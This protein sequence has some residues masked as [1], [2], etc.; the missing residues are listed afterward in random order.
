MSYNPSRLQYV[1]F[2]VQ[3]AWGT[4]ETSGFAPVECGPV[5][6][7]FG[8][9]M[10]SREAVTG[11]FYMLPPVPG[12]QAVGNEIQ[13]TIP[14]MRG[15]S[16][17]IPTGNP[18]AHFEAQVLR[19]L[20]GGQSVSGFASSAVAASSSTTV[21]KIKGA[22]SVTNYKAGN[23]LIVT[24]GAAYDLGW[25]K[26]ATSG[27]PHDVELFQAVEVTA[28]EDEDTYGTAT[29]FLGTS[30]PIF[31]TLR[32]GLLQSNTRMVYEGCVP[33]SATIS[34]NPRGALQMECTF[35]VHSIASSPGALTDYAYALPSLPAAIAANGAK[36][37]IGG[38]K[39]PFQS[40]SLSIAQEL[41]AVGSW[42][43]S[44]GVA[45]FAVTQR[46][47]SLEYAR[48][49]TTTVPALTTTADTAHAIQLGTTPG[50]MFGILMPSGV[51][52]AP[53]AIGDDEAL[54]TQ[55]FTYHAGRYAGD[56]G[57]D[58]ASN[59]P[60]RVCFG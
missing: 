50:R 20:L 22:T 13:I 36:A 35:R 3:S 30:Q 34:L 42:N 38:V 9:E 29:Q 17:A 37:W 57:A 26:Q 16:A 60:F 8:R 51:H 31:F 28:L 40:M 7:P 21:V 27:T 11:G 45:A 23:G 2:A 43:D 24:D 41:A 33:T 4:A 56:T 49:I 55:T 6:M 47:V 15:L 18:T 53:G 10:H 19:A 5:D 48:T 54:R 32:V 59:S 39:A 46:S 58:P 52:E 44:Q 14:I 1:E 12:S 25:I